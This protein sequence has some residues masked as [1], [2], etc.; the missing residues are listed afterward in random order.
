MEDIKL[1]Q[2]VG[3]LNEE[4][5]F[6]RVGTTY[7]RRIL[8]PDRYGVLCKELKVW[9][10]A[11]IVQ[12]KG[13]EYL[14]LIPHYNDFCL[15]PDNI[16]FEPIVHDCLNLYSKFAHEPKEGDC[17][18][19]MRLLEHVFGEQIEIGLRYM[20]I[21][22]MHPDRSTI[23][24]ALI[25]TER[26]TGKTTFIN[27]L[28]SIFGNNCI[29][30]GS[31]DFIGSFNAHYASRNIICIEETLLEKAISIEKLKQLTTAKSI[32]INEKFAA[33]YKVPFYGKVILTSNNETRFAKIDQAEIR[34][35]VRKLSSPKFVNH[36]IEDDLRKE[37]PAFLY[38]LKGLP[39]VNWSVSR[40][41]F[42]PAE[43]RN[44][45]L[46]NVINESKS[47]LCK[48]LEMHIEDLF[49]NN[50]N[51][52]GFYAAALDLKVKYFNYEN[53]YQPSYIGYVLRDELKMKR[54]EMMRYNP[55]IEEGAKKTGR[56]YL[57]LRCEFV[58]M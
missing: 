51:C 19:T 33:I 38:Y 41:G 49:V 46:D 17:P 44:Q 5:P 31:S 11:E 27:W 2:Q 54:Q 22:Y 7:Y 28:H 35:F 48:D 56:P 53:Q 16:N 1:S 43:L 18:W 58:K 29:T 25:S 20:R 55:F 24:L 50:P 21:L 32:T 39:P 3:E 47:S 23:I 12:D 40:S 10:K 9:Q 37:I 42:T 8:K 13:R 30:I 36:S 26:G 34:F 57:F 14:R 4:M 45:S 15:K 6:L 52:Q